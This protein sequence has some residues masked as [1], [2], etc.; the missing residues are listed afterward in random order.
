MQSR[1]VTVTGCPHRGQALMAVQGCKLWSH[2]DGLAEAPLP[3]ALS[4]LVGKG[5]AGPPVDVGGGE[6]TAEQR[7]CC[8]GGLDARQLAMLRAQVLRG[9]RPAISR[10]V[11]CHGV[12]AAC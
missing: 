5:C 6:L 11:V 3:E 4:G 12:D 7:A 2:P 1:T 9:S 10:W 8:K